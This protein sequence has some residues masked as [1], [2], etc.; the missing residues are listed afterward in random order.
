MNYFPRMRKYV[1]RCLANC[2][3]CLE[4]NYQPKKNIGF[5]HNIEKGKQPWSTLHIDHLGPLEKTTTGFRH[6]FEVID[7]FTKF[8]IFEPTKTTSTH[9]VI[10]ILLAL[11]K[12]FG[13]PK[14]IISDRGSCFT[15]FEFEEFCMEHNIIHVKAAVQ[16]PRANGQIERYNRTIM[17]AILKISSPTTWDQSLS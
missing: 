11:F 6:I 10:K 15:S 5:L 7:A 12:L 3:D 9:E 16:T 13:C 14:R 4:H 1:Q 2:L 17:P 8:S